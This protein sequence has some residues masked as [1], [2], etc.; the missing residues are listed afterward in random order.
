MMEQAR[1]IQVVWVRML[2]LLG[3]ERFKDAARASVVG[4]VSP[5]KAPAASA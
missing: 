5:E 3:R 4:D 1:T 2:M